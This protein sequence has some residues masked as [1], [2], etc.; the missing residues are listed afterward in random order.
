MPRLLVAI[1]PH[2]YGHLA[3]VAPVINHLRALVPGLQLT[4]RTTLPGSL[5]RQRIGGEFALQATA[6]DFGMV[7]HEALEAD[8]QRSLQ[9]YREFHENF[10]QQVERVAQ[11]LEAAKPDLIFADVPY[12]TLAAAAHAGIPAVAMCSLNWHA[13]VQGYFPGQAGIES[14]LQ[15]MQQA[16]ASARIFLRPEPSMPMPGLDN[17]RDIGVVAR[18]GRN[19][20]EE[21]I[22]CGNVLAGEKLLLV[23][24]GGIA[25]RLPIERW[26]IQRCVRY[27]VPASWGVER[28][29]CVTIESCNMA[30]SD[31]EASSDVILTKPGYGSFTEAAVNGIAVLYVRRPDWPEEPYLVDWLVQ[32]TRC[33]E[34]TQEMIELGAI[35][36]L[37]QQL[38][39]QQQRPVV[40]GNGVSEA[41]EI[42]R[43]YLLSEG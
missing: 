39:D 18:P 35:E 15:Q 42:L 2:G 22:N 41:A 37:V 38:L 6:D 13:I 26:P 27:I 34:L 43:D 33:M 21:L 40:T 10:P 5:L 30:F 24:M 31:L 4:L 28:S 20:R 9:R 12:L 29:D 32:H 8:T 17:L 36:P 7:Q 14:M 11:E 1:S 3:Q 19:R 16:Y 23:A 25:Q